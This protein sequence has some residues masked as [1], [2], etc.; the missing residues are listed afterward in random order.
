LQS[1]WRKATGGGAERGVKR[2]RI[3]QENWRKKEQ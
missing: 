2:C 3:A 1:R